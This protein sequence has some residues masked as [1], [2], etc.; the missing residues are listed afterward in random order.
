MFLELRP[1]IWSLIEICFAS[2]MQSPA[3]LSLHVT[4]GKIPVLLGSSKNTS[5]A[6]APLKHLTRCQADV[7]GYALDNALIRV[8]RPDGEPAHHPIANESAIRG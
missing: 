2:Q 4:P 3:C 8:T 7:P 1:D 6:V 5:S